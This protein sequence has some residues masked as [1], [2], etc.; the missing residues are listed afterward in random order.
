MQEVG[1][2]TQNGGSHLRPLYFLSW[3]THVGV[4]LLHPLIIRQRFWVP[5]MAAVCYSETRTCD[6]GLPKTQGQ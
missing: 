6:L 3:K 4:V 2:K 1:I 5:K